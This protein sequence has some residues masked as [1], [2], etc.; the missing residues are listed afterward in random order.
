MKNDNHTNVD[1]NTDLNEPL[2]NGITVADP[3]PAQVNENES[4]VDQNSG[5]NERPPNNVP[6]AG[7]PLPQV[8]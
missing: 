2:L 1:E 6:V 7:P 8:K 3:L 4:N 5:L